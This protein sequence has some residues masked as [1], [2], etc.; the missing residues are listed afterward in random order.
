[1]KE[2]KLKMKP[3]TVFGKRGA[4]WLGTRALHI[5]FMPESMPASYQL[6]T[7]LAPVI[8]HFADV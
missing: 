6:P 5:S 4:K 1:M 7:G 8:M 3:L 2:T